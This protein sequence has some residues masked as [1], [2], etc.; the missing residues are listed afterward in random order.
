MRETHRHPWRCRSGSPGGRP[1]SRPAT[2]GGQ[3]EPP[4]IRSDRAD[5]GVT[6]QALQALALCDLVAD[7]RSGITRVTVVGAPPRLVAAVHEAAAGYG[8]IASAPPPEAAGRDRVTLHRPPPV[9]GEAGGGSA[10]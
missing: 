6:P 8:V 5:A 9:G 3:R 2:K 4:A 10:D 1:S 7:P